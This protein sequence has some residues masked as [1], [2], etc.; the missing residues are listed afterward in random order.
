MTQRLYFYWLAEACGDRPADRTARG[1]RKNK[2][3]KKGKKE[4]KM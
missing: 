2:E 1:K 4:I 3:G